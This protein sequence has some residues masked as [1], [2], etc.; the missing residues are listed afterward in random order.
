MPATKR[1]NLETK[2]KKGTILYHDSSNSLWQGDIRECVYTGSKNYVYYDEEKLTLN[3]FCKLHM[4]ETRTDLKCPNVNVW[5]NVYIIDNRNRKVYI[6]NLDNLK[7]NG[8]NNNNNNILDMNQIICNDESVKKQKTRKIKKTRKKKS[9]K[10]KLEEKVL[11]SFEKEMRSYWNNCSKQLIIDYECKERITFSLEKIKSSKYS[12]KYALLN[13]NKQ[14]L[15]IAQFWVDTKNEIPKKYKNKDNIVSPFG[16]QLYEYV[17]DQES[18]FH[19]LPKKYY[20]Q[21]YYNKDLDEFKDTHEIF[22]L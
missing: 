21:Y 18:P 3:K 6:N 14:T 7:K 17:M 15:G 1:R 19:E 5:I 4:L 12:D 22:N 8:D 20:R 10:K 9:I 11:S 16:T 2:L 13:Q